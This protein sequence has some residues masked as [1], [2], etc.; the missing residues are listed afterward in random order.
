MMTHVLYG[1]QEAAPSEA[2]LED[3]TGSGK[4]LSIPSLPSG[5]SQPG[6]KFVDHRY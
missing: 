5:L 6:L 4:Q 3:F 1:S 2:I